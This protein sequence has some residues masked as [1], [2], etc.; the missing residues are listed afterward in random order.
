MGATMRVEVD[1]DSDGL[2]ALMNGSGL[3]GAC[4]KAAERIAAEA[5]D[6]FH[7]TREYHPGTRVL[8]RVYGD[9][10]EAL[11]AESDEK[12]LSRAVSA[13]RS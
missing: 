3:A 11:I 1:I 5:G 6:G 7:V 10:D 13:C 2:R 8:F 9:T 12:A 4:R